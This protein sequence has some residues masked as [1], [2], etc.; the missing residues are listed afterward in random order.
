[1]LRVP[2]ASGDSTA[3]LETPLAL[4]DLLERHRAELTRHCSR[5]LGT[6][7]EAEDAVQET[8]VRAWRSHDRFEG[9]SSLRTW[10]YQIATNVCIDMLRERQRRALPM[11]LSS[12]DSQLDTSLLRPRQNESASNLGQTSDP[13]ELAVTRESVR[14]ALFLALHYLPRRQRTAL[15]LR[16]TLG[17]RPIEIAEYLDTSVASVNSAL[18]RGRATLASTDLDRAP[19][20]LADERR[21]SLVARYVE[22]LERR[23]V[24]SLT[25]LASAHS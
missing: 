3:R 13:A 6:S 8:M 1:M 19:P 11:D 22:A 21:R 18:Q 5:M 24:A 10:L 9:R 23:D 15:L 2:A 25:T 16:E 12:A 4:D 20:G 7:F 17:W 14:L